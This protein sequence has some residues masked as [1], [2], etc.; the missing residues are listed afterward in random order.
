MEEV[1]IYEKPTCSKCRVALQ[2]LNESGV[3]YRTVRY[4]D[5]PLTKKKLKELITKLGISP[6]E[7]VRADDARDMKI[8]YK[9]LNDDEIVSLMVKYPDLM[10][11]PILEKGDKAIIGRPSDRVLEFIK[12]D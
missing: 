11:R 10:Q 8:E 3:R 2:M 1:V 9:H 5:T 7:L 6:K 12:T 4:H